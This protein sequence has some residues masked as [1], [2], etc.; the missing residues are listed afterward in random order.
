M[1]AE[2]DDLFADPIRYEPYDLRLS[3][4]PQDAIAACTEEAAESFKI[5]EALKQELTND[6]YH[7]GFANYYLG[8]RL[9]LNTPA[10]QKAASPRQAAAI[11]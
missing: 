9:Q 8:P 10:V 6:T 7:A 3:R 2:L 11:A 5:S 4:L 1:E